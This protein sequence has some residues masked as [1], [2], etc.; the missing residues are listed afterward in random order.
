MHV[1]ATGISRAEK[2]KARHREKKTASVQDE[3]P[4]VTVKERAGSRDLNRGRRNKLLFRSLPVAR[5]FLRVL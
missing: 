3:A 2:P 4:L 5:V 1:S